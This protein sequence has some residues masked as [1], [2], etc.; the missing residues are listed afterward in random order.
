MELRYDQRGHVCTNQIGMVTLG[1]MAQAGRSLR[2][3]HDLAD[4]I[5][6]R[7][8]EC[9][10]LN[11]DEIQVLGTYGI[12]GSQVLWLRSTVPA[13]RKQLLSSNPTSQQSVLPAHESYL[14]V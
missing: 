4:K 7:L 3:L 5:R 6:T 14:D 13:K 9:F 11:Y 8:M 12:D 2:G 1:S 10:W